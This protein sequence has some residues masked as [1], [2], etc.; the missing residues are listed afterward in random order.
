MLDTEQSGASENT[1]TSS[2]WADLS[3]CLPAPWLLDRN[4][5]VTANRSDP[6][7]IAF[8]MLRTRVRQQMKENNWKSVLITSPTAGCG[9]TVVS[10]NLAFSMAN[11]KDCRTVLVDLDMHRPQVGTLLGATSAPPLEDFLNERIDVEGAFKRYGRNIAIAC[12]GRPLNFASEL[13]QSPGAIKV[14]RNLRQKLA[15]DVLI[16]DMPPMLANDDVAAFLPNVD[17]AILVV[18]AEQTTLAE[19]DLC[20]RELAEKTNLLGV[21][22]NKCRY[23]PEKYGY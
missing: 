22:L 10:L 18:A 20:E 7:H 1:S 5:I 6:A 19:V 12:N 14:L 11:Q 9:K 17:C 2:G 16:F 13:L 3:A 15:P 8:D 23:A 21:V 4:R